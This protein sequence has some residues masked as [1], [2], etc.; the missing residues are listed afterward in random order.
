MKFLKITYR[1]WNLCGGG[2]RVCRCRSAHSCGLVLV[3]QHSSAKIQKISICLVL[4]INPLIFCTNICSYIAFVIYWKLLF[5]DKKKKR[6]HYRNIFGLMEMQNSSRKTL[7]PYISRKH[8]IVEELIS[9]DLNAIPCPYIP[10]KRS[11]FN[12]IN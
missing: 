10:C 8:W 5:Y 11:M 9:H 7:R 1:T 3:F 2:L 4:L 12:R 6:G